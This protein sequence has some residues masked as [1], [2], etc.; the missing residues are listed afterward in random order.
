MESLFIY[1]WLQ[2]ALQLFWQ[3]Q[4]D[5]LFG[6]AQKTLKKLQ[7]LHPNSLTLA[8]LEGELVGISPDGGLWRTE[9]V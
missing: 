2:Q 3:S 6:K 7:A 4:Q 5:E 8:W 1:R 9:Q